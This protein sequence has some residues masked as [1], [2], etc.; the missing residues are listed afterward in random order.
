[1]VRVGRGRWMRFETGK[2]LVRRA[3]GAGTGCVT[4]SECVGAVGCR[5]APG[6]ARH[7][8]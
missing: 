7:V 8:P 1:V 4:G 2:Q 3:P 5:H 6:K